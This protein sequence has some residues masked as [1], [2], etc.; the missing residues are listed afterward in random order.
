[1]GQNG[2]TS[3]K[4][5]VNA[6]VK[7]AYKPHGPDVA[8]RPGFGVAGCPHWI[9]TTKATHMNLLSVATQQTPSTLYNILSGLTRSR[10]V[11]KR[12]TTDLAPVLGAVVKFHD[13]SVRMVTLARKYTNSQPATR[14]KI[15]RWTFNAVSYDL[16]TCEHVTT[17]ITLDKVRTLALADCGIESKGYIAITPKRMYLILPKEEAQD[18]IARPSYSLNR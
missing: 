14:D 4:T 17:P 13:V 12:I 3:R 9:A 5:K 7:R 15:G 6:C 1:M 8:R 10:A 11:S 2:R 18:V 16:V